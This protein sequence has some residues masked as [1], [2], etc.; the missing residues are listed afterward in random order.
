MNTEVKALAFQLT[1][2]RSAFILIVCVSVAFI[3][4]NNQPPGDEA[5]AVVGDDDVSAAAGDC[6][7]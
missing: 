2:D 5:G 1:V 6:P 3:S 7:V 4:T